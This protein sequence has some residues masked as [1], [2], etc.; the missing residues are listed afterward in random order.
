MQLDV[1]WTPQSLHWLVV[2]DYSQWM[3][4]P[5]AWQSAARHKSQNLEPRICR[6]ILGDPVS[7]LHWQCLHSFVHVSEETIKRLLGTLDV[8]HTGEERGRTNLTVRQAMILSVV[9]TVLP[10]TSIEQAL[11]SLREAREAEHPRQYHVE[12]VEKEI[13]EDVMLKTD[14]PEIQTS[15]KEAELAAGVASEFE[16][17]VRSDVESYSWGK[18]RQIA[19]QTASKRQTKPEY[20]DKTEAIK[21]KQWLE[22]YLPKGSS[23]CCDESNQRMQMCYKAAGRRLSRKSYSWQKRGAK[24]CLNECLD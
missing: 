16:L 10:D 22:V 23:C 17:K 9:A 18:G 12:S 20:L 24:H 7:L 13:V 14:V 11:Q 2:T 3:V 6:R 1:Q 21:M 15:F 4:V 8:M 5:T 19:P